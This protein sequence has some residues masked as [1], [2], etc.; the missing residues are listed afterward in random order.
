M[1][2]LYSVLKLCNRT[3]NAFPNFKIKQEWGTGRGRPIIGYTFTFDKEKNNQ[4]EIDRKK[5][6][7]IA[8]FWKSEE[9]ELRKQKEETDKHSASF[10][11]LLKGWF[12][13]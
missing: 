4:Y 5:E 3:T 11:D 1:G 10:G 8:Q 7:Q 2:L 9:P 12:K 6:E 13:K